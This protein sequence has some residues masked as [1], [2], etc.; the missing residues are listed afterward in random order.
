MK[1]A[2]GFTLVELLVVVA[3]S[4]ILAAIVVP[5]V[6]KYILRAQVARAQE[7]INS[8]E[9]SLTSLLSAAGARDFRHLFP[10]G[11]LTALMASEDVYGRMMYE[12]L[13][14]GRDS[15]IAGSMRPEI[16]ER[17]G[18][19]YLADIGRDPWGNLYQIYPGPWP[20][21]AG[22]IPFRSFRGGSGSVEEGTWTPFLYDADGKAYEDENVPG[23][24]PPD[25]SYGYPAPRDFTFYIWSYGPN[26][27]ND[28]LFGT[29]E[30]GYEGGGDD[31]NN[32][33]GTAGWMAFVD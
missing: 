11:T 20:R 10:A 14:Q 22:I 3:I 17:L 2:S 7:E 8:I 15:E 6:G 26:M 1:R 23:N 27:L 30:A 5:Q 19:S 13:R 31:V 28:Q 18:T 32:W 25:D 21:T 33:D 4:S 16:Q 29:P 9:T 24:P 12:L